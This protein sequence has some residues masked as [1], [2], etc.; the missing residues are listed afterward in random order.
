M[1]VSHVPDKPGVYSLYKGSECIYVGSSI[2]MRTRLRGHELRLIADSVSFME[3]N[4]DELTVTEQITLDTS[5]PTMN[6][7]RKISRT[8][9]LKYR[10]VQAVGFKIE[11][12]DLSLLELAMKKFQ[13]RTSVKISR[14]GAI[15]LA[16]RLFA[17][18]EGV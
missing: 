14:S 10:E 2:R 4:E 12:K 15:S 3:C 16:I 7:K 17:K 5:N 13:D 1:N 18:K 11:S 6:K 9:G 8:E